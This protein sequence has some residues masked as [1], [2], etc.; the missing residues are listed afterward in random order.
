MI[1]RSSTIHNNYPPPL[2][3]LDYCDEDSPT[4][5]SQCLTRRNK[6][7]QSFAFGF[8]SSLPAISFNTRLKILPD[9][10][11]GISSMNL[12]P[13]RSRLWL[14]TLLETYTAAVS[15]GRQVA[16]IQGA[17]P[18]HNIIRI[19]RTSILAAFG[20]HD[21]S[22]WDFSVL[23]VVM[24]S[25]DRH[26]VDQWVVHQLPFQLCRCYLESTQQICQ[27]LPTQVSDYARLT[28]CT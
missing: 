27:H 11:F 21:I 5:R 3:F 10:V 8:G 16:E 24:D 19:L 20:V 18:I 23:F 4:G 28:P 17:Y 25:D 2:R 12:T 6:C 13:P 7:T 1:T 15:T 9:A 22:T 26:V 14:A